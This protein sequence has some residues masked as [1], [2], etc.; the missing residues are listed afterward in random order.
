MAPKVLAVHVAH[1]DNVLHGLPA[2]ADGVEAASTSVG[3]PSSATVLFT[4][5]MGRKRLR[6]CS[7]GV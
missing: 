4:R 3:M 7:S 2:A 6:A 5:A 1:A